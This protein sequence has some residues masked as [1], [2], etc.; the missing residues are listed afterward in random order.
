MFCAKIT[1]KGLHAHKIT[2]YPWS[3]LGGLG[4][5]TR[6]LRGCFGDAGSPGILVNKLLGR[7]RPSLIF[8]PAPLIYKKKLLSN[9]HGLAPFRSGVVT[10]TNFLKFRGLNFQGTIP[11]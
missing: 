6:V 2:T 1:R 8:L 10:S 5:S 7:P 11:T 3:T 4:K 9:F